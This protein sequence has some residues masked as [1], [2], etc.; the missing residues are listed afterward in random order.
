MKGYETNFQFLACSYVQKQTQRLLAHID[1]TRKGDDIE[2]IHQA[3]V[4]SR[5]IRTAIGAFKKAFPAKK[6]RRWNKHIRR[7][8]QGLGAARDKDVQIE[9]VAGMVA[10]R[11]AEKRAD[12]PGLKRLLLRLRQ[13]REAIQP[14]V[15]KTLDQLE[16][17]GI[18]SQ[19]LAHTAKSLSRLQ[20]TDT[21]TK[22]P[23]VLER[24]AR[25]IQKTC[26]RMLRLQSCLD[27]AEAIEQHHR[28]RI[29]AKKLRYTIEIY[30]KAFDTRLNESHKVIRNIQTL[31]GD[32]HD[33]DVWCEFI[34]TFMH[35]E[36]QRTVEYY[37]HARPFQRLRS[38]L[39]YLRNERINHRRE[40]F[41]E[42]AALWKD[43]QTGGFW[44]KLFATL[45]A[46]H[47]GAGSRVSNNTIIQSGGPA[48]IIEDASISQS[49]EE[50]DRMPMTRSQVKSTE[51]RNEGKERSSSQK[52]EPNKEGSQ[53][54]T[55]TNDGSEAEI[56][57]PLPSSLVEKNR[58]FETARHREP[59]LPDPSAP[60]SP[61][62]IDT[63]STTNA[64]CECCSRNSF[65]PD[66]LFRIDSGQLLCPKCLDEFRKKAGHRAK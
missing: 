31:L 49:S 55:S 13:E 42:L 14:R 21:D 29:V 4:A 45:E 28:M 52:P 33:C 8:I 10:D 17:T 3:R 5:R 16:T 34:Q 37:G 64:I 15:I 12:L 46:P 47:A 43:L 18:V 20:K 65:L 23:L 11:I 22:S 6:V 51:I 66:E 19:M 41:D 53:P 30:K 54:G 36:R 26:H 32:I 35:E 50:P 27:D 9:F 60:D 2:S 40:T 44:E 61:A 59:E 24:G 7:L 58:I 56:N 25:D 39:E 1:G 48:S 57:E 62:A 38:G 63:P